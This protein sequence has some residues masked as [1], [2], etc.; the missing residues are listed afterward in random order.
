[1]KIVVTKRSDDWHACLANQKG[2]WEAG[3][4]SDEAIGKLIVS[5][6]TGL[7]L[8]VE[9]VVPPPRAREITRRK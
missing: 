4:T 2:K 1:M 3:R 5:H 7:G 6:A 9:F 8:E